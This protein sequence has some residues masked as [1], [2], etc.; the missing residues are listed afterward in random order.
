M[1]V[2]PT[3]AKYFI[4]VIYFPITSIALMDPLDSVIGMTTV[5]IRLGFG[6]EQAWFHI[7]FVV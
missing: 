2:A 7:Y 3:D 1:T 5:D 4:K 6:R